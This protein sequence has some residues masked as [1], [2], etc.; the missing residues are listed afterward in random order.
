MN[1]SFMTYLFHKAVQNSEYKA[2]ALALPQRARSHTNQE[3]TSIYIQTTNKDEPISNITEHLF[4]RGHFGYLYNLLIQAIQIKKE[5]NISL[6]E[7]TARILELQ[8]SFRPL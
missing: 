1:R 4:N 6:D 5:N 7:E 3:S 2:S 8:K